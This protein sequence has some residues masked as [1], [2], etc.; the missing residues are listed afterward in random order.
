MIKFVAEKFLMWDARRAVEVGDCV[1]IGEQLAHK[2]RG[3]E[4]SVPSGGLH[5][6]LAKIQLLS[7]K[8]WV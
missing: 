4:N 3:K 1:A 6:S 2:L 7:R 5:V 8:I